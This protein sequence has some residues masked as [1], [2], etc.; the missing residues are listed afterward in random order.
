MPFGNPIP[1]IMGSAR[2]R[3][4][5]LPGIG[6]RDADA[7]HEAVRAAYRT[8]TPI[9]APKSINPAN[10]TKSPPSGSRQMPPSGASV[11]DD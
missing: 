3:L 2:K 11:R 1:N 6:R 9:D 5:K 8:D 10:T 4:A 7:F